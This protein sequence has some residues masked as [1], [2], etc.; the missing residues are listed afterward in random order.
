[1]LNN[2]IKFDS[3]IIKLLT[4]FFSFDKNTI[5]VIKITLTLN[6]FYLPYYF[7]CSH[8]HIE[9]FNNHSQNPF[10]TKNRYILS[11]HNFIFFTRIPTIIDEHI[12]FHRILLR[13][14]QILANIKGQR[15]QFLESMFPLKYFV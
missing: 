12:K 4:T 2:L 8:F 1:M 7:I 14:C 9:N 10:H 15:R 11:F 3:Y 13:F 6:L 5:F